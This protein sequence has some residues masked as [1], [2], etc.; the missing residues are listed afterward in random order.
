[1]MKELQNLR[2]E[3]HA[4]AEKSGA[5]KNTAEIIGQY[6]EGFKPH[7]VITGLGGYGIAAVFGGNAPGPRLLIRCELDALPIPETIQLDYGA[8]AG[9]VAHKCGHDGHMA[10]VLGL[11]PVLS[12]RPPGKGSVVLLFQPAEEIGKG[13]RRVIE[14][15]RFGEITPDYCF[16][17]HNLPGFAR[18]RII[19]R[20][21]SFAAASRGLTVK[22]HGATS[23]AAEPEKGNSPT[24]AVAQLIHCFSSM[25]QFYTGLHEAAK[26][27]VIHSRI[28]EIA[29][30][31][32]PGE[33]EVMATLR[34]YEQDVMERLSGKCL[35]L[36][37][38]IARANDLTCEIGWDEEFPA[39]VNN[40]DC[41]GLIKKCASQLNLDIYEPEK[42]FPW[43]E[44][45]GNFTT[46][47]PGALF[48]LG[49]GEEHPGLH[50]PTY[51]FPD[52]ILDTGVKMFE[53]IVHELT[54]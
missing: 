35:D 20:E 49:A 4:A 6:L 17:L 11:A 25:P 5:E 44:D 8:T 9:G 41:A 36:V 22:L 18:H 13:A 26:V 21:G 50:H 51:D 30:G 53:G 19:V 39:T 42:P 38:G 34:A 24:M 3:L 43:S 46:L 40:A 27:T 14:D 7:Q 12:A 28:G 2:H 10:I 23:H 54:D 16:A 1:M 37:K 29:F 45:F 15:M 52:E 33:A 32:S 48:G 47:C 31:T